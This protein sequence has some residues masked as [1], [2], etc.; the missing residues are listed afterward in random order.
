MA[1]TRQ[2]NVRWTVADTAGNVGT[3]EQA[4][5][6]ILMDIRDEL[7]TL[8]RIFQCPNFQGIPW[9]VKKVV[10][11]TRKPKRKKPAVKLRRVA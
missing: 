9:D 1:D 6:A 2:K 4:Q 5:A 3:W 11:N 7:Q 8:V 10:A